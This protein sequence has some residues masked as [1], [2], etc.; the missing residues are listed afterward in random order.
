MNLYS[1]E[2]QEQIEVLRD[3]FR[4][5]LPMMLTLLLV[6][7]VGFSGHSFWS[8]YRNKENAQA[9]SYY[10]LFQV[11]INAE[12]F[13]KSQ[14]A[15]RH[16]QLNFPLSPYSYLA[17]LAF[18]AFAVKEK[19][20]DDALS[21]LTWMIDKGDQPWATLAIVR[22]VPIAIDARKYDM[23]KEFLSS[24]SLTSFKPIILMEQGDLEIVQGRYADAI[25]LYRSA[26]EI[27][28]ERAQL[29]N[30]SWGVHD[31]ELQKNFKSLIDERIR[32]AEVLS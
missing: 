18:S 11:G 21:V 31:S 15:L 23:A 30:K 28:S 22:A 6:A 3:L 20:T 16:L 32:C 17:S 2:E 14:Q 29:D 24:P 4:K 5:Y 10:S 27:M 13:G 8:W 12:D 25:S 19:K 26:S 9:L 1:Q 7:V